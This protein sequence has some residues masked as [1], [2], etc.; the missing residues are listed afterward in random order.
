MP[1]VAVNAQDNRNRATS[2]IVSDALAQMPAETPAVYNQ[3]MAELA[4]TGA[5]GIE[6]LAMMLEPMAEGV[7]N[8]PVEYAVNGV[9]SYV[10]KEGAA[11]REGVCAGLKAA[12]AKTTNN[13]NKAFLTCES[14][15]SWNFVCWKSLFYHSLNLIACD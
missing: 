13:P 4:A 10:T 6:M 9:A 12:I 1:L 5:E 14:I 7:N 11:M 8:S 15:W 3:V 2:T